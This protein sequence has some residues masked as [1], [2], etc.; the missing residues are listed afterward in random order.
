MSKDSFFDEV[1]PWNQIKSN[2]RRIQPIKT[3][4]PGLE[5]SHLTLSPLKLTV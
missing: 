4:T 5:T 3:L 2:S 1:E